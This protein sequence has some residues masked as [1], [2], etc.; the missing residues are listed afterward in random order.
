M[1][2]SDVEQQSLFDRFN[3]SSDDDND[4]NDESAMSLV[5]HLEELRKR[6]FVCLIFVAVG[7]VIAF[8]FRT[9]IISL[10]DAP[11][12]MRSDTLA[13]ALGQKL[14]VTGLGEAFTVSIKLSIVF[15]LVFALPSIL[16]ETWAFVAPGLY[17]KEKQ[18][19]V[20]FILLGLL[21]FALGLTLGY[22]ILQF[23]VA[24]LINFGSGSFNELITADSYF[25]F[26]AYFLLVFGAIFELPLVL[27]FLALIHVISEDFLKSKRAIAH[28][29]MWA[30]STVLTPGADLYSPVFIGIS[31]SVL[32]EF[33]IILIHFTIK[34]A[35]AEEIA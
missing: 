3:R 26:V 34:K 17:D 7:T 13:K 21:L 6:I 1:A 20:P 8:I 28:V 23:P 33:S 31:L 27:S 35:P 12:P 9:Q 30:A 29:I 18:H 24:F 2:A 16:Y 15:G 5:E 25:T 11:L 32:Y 19:A 22:F 4:D 14:T 10:L